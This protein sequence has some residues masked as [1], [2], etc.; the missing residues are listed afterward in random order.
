MSKN[1]IKNI[2]KK[3]VN[4]KKIIIVVA[5]GVLLVA[6]GAGALLLLGGEDAKVENTD[7][8]REEGSKMTNGTKR[9]VGE[10]RQLQAEVRNDP[11]KGRDEIMIRY[12]DLVNSAPD[13]M[14][15]QMILLNQASYLMAIKEY[16]EALVVATRAESVL[17]DSSSASLVALIAETKGDRS[18]AIEYYGKLLAYYEDDNS[19][20]SRQSYRDS[21][22][23]KIKRLESGG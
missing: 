2:P 13:D 18:L 14:D 21:V 17:E 20:S 9:V 1:I 5:I 4:K 15:K 7:S 10:L 8:V 12:D 23:E 19:E 22:E 3:K 16:D 11:D 6:G